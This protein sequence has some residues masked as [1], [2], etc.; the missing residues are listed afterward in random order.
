LSTSI[1]AWLAVLVQVERFVMGRP[2]WQEV[3]A[4]EEPS[5]TPQVADAFFFAGNN[6]YV[7]HTFAAVR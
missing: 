6:D 4:A 5:N 7:V 2:P 1:K 3:E